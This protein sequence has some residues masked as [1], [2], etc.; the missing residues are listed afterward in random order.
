MAA[1]RRESRPVD[2]RHGQRRRRAR[3]EE[4]RQAE[5]VDAAMRLISTKGFD[6]TTVRDIAEAAGASVGSVH[7]Y[8]KTKDDLL[9]AAFNEG[10]ARFRQRTAESLERVEG[11]LRR[12]EVLVELCFPE[13]SEADPE[14]EV[15]IDLWQQAA[16]HEKYQALF[17]RANEEWVDFIASVLKE[18][19][20]DGEIA[21][22]RDVHLEAISLAALID[23]LGIYSRT[24]NH[25]DRQVARRVALRRLEN[26][27]G[28][29]PSQVRKRS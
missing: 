22:L 17:A 15:E 10:E 18:A 11:G 3:I 27:F 12:L 28:T 25:V 9:T 24:T 13:E 8:F 2:G 1:T 7:Y 23:G 20:R 16:R 21:E 14:W 26:L 6:R 5:L 29:A 19:I 4:V